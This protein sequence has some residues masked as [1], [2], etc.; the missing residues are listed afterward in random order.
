MVVVHL[1]SGCAT[2]LRA[3][4]MAAARSI[5]SFFLRACSFGSYLPTA[6]QRARSL[7]GCHSCTVWVELFLPGPSF[8]LYCLR[9][10]FGELLVSLHQGPSL[11]EQRQI[12]SR[13]MSGGVSANEVDVP[14]L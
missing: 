5:A 3:A 6:A 1:P 14:Q 8:A 10:P 13:Y 11:R 12:W 4:L 9:L 2:A 7:E